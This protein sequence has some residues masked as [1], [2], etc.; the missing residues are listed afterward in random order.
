MQLSGVASRVVAF[1]LKTASLAAAAQITFTQNGLITA[2]LEA[3]N[4]GWGNNMSE[5]RVSGDSFAASAGA[6]GAGG[7]ISTAPT[8]M[9][10]SPTATKF[11]NSSGGAYTNLHIGGIYFT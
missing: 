4:M 1:G 6:N 7:A 3:S 2:G 5:V 10:M 9:L 8:I 11:K